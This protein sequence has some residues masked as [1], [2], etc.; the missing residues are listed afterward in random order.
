LGWIPGHSP[1]GLRR[2]RAEATEADVDGASFEAVQLGFDNCAHGFR[3][4]FGAKI[5][6][7]FVPVRGRGVEMAFDG[8]L[9][10]V[11]ADRGLEPA[12]W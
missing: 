12:G 6:E 4:G 9:C 11:G 3:G 7:H 8:G 10:F 5:D 1:L 2:S